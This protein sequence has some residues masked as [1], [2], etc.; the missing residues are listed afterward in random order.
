MHVVP[1]LG[2]ALVGGARLFGALP[3]LAEPH[4]PVAHQARPL[5]VN[6]EPPAQL[7]PGAELLPEVRVLGELRLGVKIGTPDR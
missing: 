7:D 5:S 3:C 6:D 2:A 4:R 1:G